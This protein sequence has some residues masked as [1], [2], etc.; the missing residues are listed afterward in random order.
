[1][2]KSY[3]EA[4]VNISLANQIVKQIKPLVKKT[5]TS[6]VMSDIGSF[7]GLF[8]LAGEKCEE[9]VLVSGTDAWEQN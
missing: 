4:G 3:E 1:M 7:G 5:F 8:S 9:P 6:G 2:A